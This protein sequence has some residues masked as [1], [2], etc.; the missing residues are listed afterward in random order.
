[1]QFDE[2]LC[3]IQDGFNSHEGP[4]NGCACVSDL[5]YLL[6]CLTDMLP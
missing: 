6:F 3:D 5:N 2:H 4:L 1:M